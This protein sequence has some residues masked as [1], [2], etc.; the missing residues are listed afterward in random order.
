VV[1]WFKIWISDHFTI[2]LNIA[3]YGILGNLL[4]FLIQ[5]PADFHEMTDTEKIMNPQNF[6]RNLTDIQ[7][8]VQSGN[9]D[10]N[11]GSLLVEVR[12]LGRG[13]HSLVLQHLSI[14]ENTNHLFGGAG[15]G[16]AAHA[17]ND[18]SS[19]LCDA[20]TSQESLSLSVTS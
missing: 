1:I 2:S 6:G 4:A 12:R 19:S 13:L 14:I 17:H 18:L 5:S 20:V 10:S 11:S 7:N 9:L 3:E 15:V 8:G 16:Q